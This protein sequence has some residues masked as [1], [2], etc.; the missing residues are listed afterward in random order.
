MATTDSD[1]TIG[2]RV[3]YDRHA[4]NNLNTPSV[5]VQFDATADDYNSTGSDGANADGYYLGNPTAGSGATGALAGIIGS[6]SSN[7]GV[8]TLTSAVKSQQSFAVTDVT[9]D[10]AGVKQIATVELDSA[11]TYSQYSFTDGG[12]DPVSIRSGAG[13]AT[14]YY[15]GKVWLDVTGA[16]ADNI[17]GNGDDVSV[18]V[19]ASMSTS[20]GGSAA[21]AQNLVSVI[22]NKLDSNNIAYDSNLAGIL[23]S[24]S[25]DSVSGKITLTALNPG[26]HTFS[27]SDI[28]LDYQGLKQIATVD[29]NNLDDA[30]STA[31]TYFSGGELKVTVQPTDASGASNGQAV[32]VSANM[33]NNSES[34][35]LAALVAAI[36]AEINGAPDSVAQV[37]IGSSVSASDAVTTISSGSTFFG[38]L[39]LKFF[40]DADGAG[41]NQAVYYSARVQAVQSSTSLYWFTQFDLYGANSRSSNSRAT[42]SLGDFVTWLNSTTAPTPNLPVE[43][44]FDGVNGQL[45][46]SV[47]DPN[48]INATIGLQITRDIN[49]Q[50]G[51]YMAGYHT[52]SQPVSSPAVSAGSGVDLTD[53]LTTAAGEMFVLKFFYDPATPGAD[54]QWFTAS[55]DFYGSAFAPIFSADGLILNRSSGTVLTGNTL[56]DLIQHINN[57]FSSPTNNNTASIK[58]DV[59][60]TGE[61]TLT[62]E[63]GDT[64][65]A[66]V[67]FRVVRD[68]LGNVGTMFDSGDVS[69]FSTGATL[70]DVNGYYI[71]EP[72]QGTPGLLAPY[73]SAV[74]E[75]NGVIT[76]T[77]ANNVKQQFSISAATAGSPGAAEVTEVTFSTTDS[78]YFVTGND[79]AATAGR[80][81]MTV[82]GLTYV[83]AMQATAEATL[84]SLADAMTHGQAAANS[85]TGSQVA[86]PD[87]TSVAAIS[88]VNVTFTR[89]SGLFT[90]TGQT[91]GDDLNISGAVSVDGTRQVTKISFDQG[92]DDVDFIEGIGHEI[93]AS[94]AGQTFTLDGNSRQEVLQD[95]I[96]QLTAAITDDIANNGG[97]GIASKLQVADINLDT[98]TPSA[99]FL[100]LTARYSDDQDS[101]LGVANLTRRQID[102]QLSDHQEI[103]VGLT[104]QYLNTLTG[105]E[106]LNFSFGK[107]TVTYTVVNGHTTVQ[108]LAGIQAAMEAT[109]LIATAAYSFPT[110]SPALFT[111]V[112]AV[113]GPNVLGTVSNGLNN[114]VALTEGVAPSIINIDTGFFAEESIAGALVFVEP[115]TVTETVSTPSITTTGV[116]LVVAEALTTG[117]GNDI[118]T[119]TAAKNIT[120]ENVG[121]TNPSS[122]TGAGSDYYGDAAQ[123][124]GVTGG[125][126]NGEGVTQSYTNPGSGA[127]HISGSALD[128]STGATGATGDATFY[129]DAG[130]TG[131]N[132]VGQTYTNPTSGYTGVTGSAQVGNTGATGDATYAGDAGATGSNGVGQTYTNP[133]NGYTGV[134]GSVQ[135]GNTG[136]TGDATY[137]GDVGATGSNGV[138]QTY[139]NPASGYTGVTGSV[140]AGNTGATGDAAYYGDAAQTGGVT[141]GVFDGVGVQQTYTNPGNGYDATA[142]SPQANANGNTTNTGD[143]ALYGSNAG[144]YNDAGLWTT[145]LNGGV[146]GATGPDGNGNDLYTTGATGTDLTAVIDLDSTVNAGASGSTS[147]ADTTSTQTRIGFAAFTLDDASA[148]TGVLGNAGPDVIHNFQ[149]LYDFIQLEGMLAASTADGQVDRII[150][151]TQQS[152]VNA[153]VS[154]TVTLGIDGDS[155]RNGW[156]INLSAGLDPADFI[157]T[158]ISSSNYF[159]LPVSFPAS[160]N[161]FFGGTFA[162]WTGLAQTLS[163]LY[164]T[165]QAAPTYSVYQANN[166][167]VYIVIDN[168]AAT[169]DPANSPGFSLTVTTGASFDLSIDEFGLVASADSTLSSAQISDAGQVTTLLNSLFDFSVTTDNNLINTSVFAVT[170][171]DD[172]T[173]TAIWAHRQSADND[174]T[175]EA[176][177]LYLLAT[178][179]TTG[180][181]FQ[182][183]NLRIDTGAP[184]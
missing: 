10:Y 152:Q 153:T 161:D 73:V 119:T 46:M 109:D 27:V 48:A 122:G 163:T 71:G 118:E 51:E 3:S 45:T 72:A 121:Y 136:A 123:T 173:Q 115:P 88:T 20:Y 130:A 26:E 33:V 171:Q 78:D 83:V 8:I 150:G 131:S 139:T 84:A 93:T 13:P 172:P 82:N 16:G 30:N 43:F 112:A 59:S 58:F 106:V 76:L 6:A 7:G 99:P 144:Y 141:G 184:V 165:W 61:L 157:N 168:N 177:E 77:S 113:Q 138:G 129:G 44:A 92:F 178:L 18:S 12:G 117:Q 63:D 145:Y 164:P 116:D 91:Q 42:A 9:L 85:L 14:Y 146:T 36:Q 90:F 158:T 24:A 132:G 162:G 137:A 38:D 70:A 64:N 101:M 125:A 100:E 5:G 94:V 148:A 182:L 2:F 154:F 67:G 55:V 15:G 183:Q 75:S 4:S 49:D 40:Y 167:D 23:S 166:G 29:F 87:G 102:T 17:I 155:T 52:S 60:P 128:G 81:S 126:F 19:S 133:T 62:T 103:V 176:L 160:N 56:S 34:G 156:K 114:T 53:I 41:V 175:V 28:T 25:Y 143:P 149:P 79:L 180:E 151:A 32:V 39:I 86:H 47:R 107:T 1:A 120:D 80:V 170:A 97:N 174:A 66:S 95:L 96:D 142:A 89:S 65:P 54:R 98:T 74:S 22:N 127:I 110:G 181:E 68:D 169:P 104:R 159:S 11:A 108:T 69:Y 21:T 134:T 35:S 111:L 50:V 147:S 140:Q 135:A 105:G 37:A 124:G 31:I 57:Y 179:T